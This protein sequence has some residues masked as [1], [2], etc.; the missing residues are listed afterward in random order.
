MNETKNKVDEKT[1]EVKDEEVKHVHRKTFIGDDLYQCA[2][3]DVPECPNTYHQI[4]DENGIVHIDQLGK[5]EAYQDTLNA[6]G[7]N[8]DVNYLLARF[9]AGD[10][11][12]V[13]DIQSG[14][15][16]DFDG[17]MTDDPYESVIA[18][19][20]AFTDSKYKLHNNPLMTEFLDEYGS[21][22]LKDKKTF[23]DSFD[24][25]VAKKK[26]ALKPVEPKK[27]EEVNNG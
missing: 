26:E 12:I 17:G 20:E 1:G 2:K 16:L 24:K 25:F 15:N 4:E 27:E 14:L 7:K 18:L 8:T 3:L 13:S 5:D 6:L 19:F 10:P 22:V 21:A 11:D 9:A 23:F